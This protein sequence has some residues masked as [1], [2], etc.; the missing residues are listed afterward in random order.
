M[1][2]QL[3]SPLF[4]FPFDI[5]KSEIVPHVARNSKDYLS[6]IR[7]C[8]RMYI[9]LGPYENYYM[10]YSDESILKLFVNRMI[11]R[12]KRAYPNHYDWPHTRTTLLNPPLG[13][14]YPVVEIIRQDAALGPRFILKEKKTSRKERTISAKRYKT[15]PS[16]ALPLI[17][18]LYVCPDTGILYRKWPLTD[19][20]NVCGTVF[21]HKPEEMFTLIG[22]TIDRAIAKSYHYWYYR[23]SNWRKWLFRHCMNCDYDS[24]RI[25]L[26]VSMPV[27]NEPSLHLLNIVK[28]PLLLNV[29]QKKLDEI[30]KFKGIPILH[31]HK[32]DDDEMDLL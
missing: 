4:S 31:H 19:V 27:L 15:E 10:L 26:G 24:Y 30:K 14:V 16:I 2:L 17:I 25:L 21:M 18:D 9:L 28:I 22:S 7:T 20:K 11:N 23:S 5:I 13:K 6:L 32:E 12:V 3:E 29:T 1:N 8:K